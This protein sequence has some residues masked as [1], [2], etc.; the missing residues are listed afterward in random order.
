MTR[1]SYEGARSLIQETE[2]GSPI[3]TILMLPAVWRVK[4][5]GYQQV[6]AFV[7]ESVDLSVVRHSPIDGNPTITD[8]S[9]SA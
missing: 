7:P 3:T 6:I 5:S 1:P 4:L 2:I 9:I 8:A